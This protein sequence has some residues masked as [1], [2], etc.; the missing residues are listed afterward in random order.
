[1]R[2]LRA[3]RE[4]LSARTHYCRALRASTAH[5][6]PKRTRAE[7]QQ[8]QVHASWRAPP[9]GAAH[10]R[11]RAR[12]GAAQRRDCLHGAVLRAVPGH[13][14]RLR[15]GAARAGVAARHAASVHGTGARERGEGGQAGA[16]EEADSRSGYGALATVRSS[17]RL[18]AGDAVRCRDAH[19]AAL[20]KPSLRVCAHASAGASRL[21][22]ARWPHAPRG[23]SLSVRPPQGRV[24]G[25]CSDAGALVPA[26]LR[27][28]HPRSCAA[29]AKPNAARSRR[30]L[31]HAADLREDPDGQDHHAG[32]GVFGHH[33]RVPGVALRATVGLTRIDILL[34][35]PAQT[36]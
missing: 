36:T 33:R 1:M 30:R 17:G 31:A 25:S 3:P 26:R 5:G 14:E 9:H 20:R 16:G 10:Q 34:A 23:I 32:G 27:A 6:E 28:T 11:T 15:S 29:C 8:Q 12:M 2:P 24:R 21:Q 35:A 13:G 7:Q 18:G 4:A 22:A 19:D